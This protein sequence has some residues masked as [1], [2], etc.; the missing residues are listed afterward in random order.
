MD[1]H[2]GPTRIS[3]YIDSGECLLHCF[4]EL[5]RAHPGASHRYIAAAIGMKSSA[6]FAL[7]VQGRIHPTPPII[8][9]LARVFG[10]DPEDRNH[11]A[12]LFEFRRIRDPSVRRMLMEMITVRAARGQDSR[13]LRPAFTN[14]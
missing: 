3:E 14:P 6:S 7:L 2:A 12:L 8:D 4:R 13:P 11:L 9:A 10:L 5:K 1:I